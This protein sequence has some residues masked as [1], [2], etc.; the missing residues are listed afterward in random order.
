ME[1]F[2]RILHL[3]GEE[4][5]QRL[6]KK[7]ITVIGLGAVGGFALE[8]LARSGV[9]NFRI[10]DFDKVHK[11]NINRQLLALESTVGEF[12]TTLAKKRI[13]DINP[14]SCVETMNLFVHEDTMER[15]LD[16]APD[17][18]IDAIDSLKPKTL[19]LNALYQRNI[20]VISS[21]GAALKTNPALIKTGDLMDTK[22]CRLARMLKRKLRKLGVGKGIRC[23][24]SEEE[25][26]H[27]HF[28]Y[29]KELQEDEL[30]RG[31]ERRVLGSIP[32]ITG[33]FGLTLANEAIFNI[34]NN[35]S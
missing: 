18:V 35:N 16:N 32:T 13:L 17:M 15:V 29:Y 25:P 30:G 8:A 1:R 10:I 7:S 22:H 23:V 27:N 14:N 3:I 19:L 28:Q 26:V 5:F 6:Q 24:Y 12:K 20:P 4:N 34:L 9:Q 21:M 31:R 2:S 11:S 33:I